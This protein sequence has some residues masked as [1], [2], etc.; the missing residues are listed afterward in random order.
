VLNFQNVPI[1]VHVLP[2]GTVLMWGRRDDH[3]SRLESLNEHFCTPFVWDPADPV[4]AADSTVAKTTST[5]QPTLA[6]GET[7]NLFCG[8]HAFLPYGRLLAAGGHLFDGSGV[9]QASLYTRGRDGSPGMW[10]ATAPMEK[11]RWYP[12]ATTLPDGGVLVL[13]GSYRDNPSDV[14]TPP[15]ANPLVEV[16][17]NHTWRRLQPFPDTVM[18]YFPRAHVLSSGKVFISGTLT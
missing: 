8:G 9:N 11:G 7:V 5:A 6:S 18:D 13:G 17:S 14:N 2:D 16:W 12:T 4:E 15:I 3:S 10:S 1:H